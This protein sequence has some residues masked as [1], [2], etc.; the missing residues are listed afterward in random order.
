MR[1]A[2]TLSAVA[3]AQSVGAV[4]ASDIAF[5]LARIVY[6]NHILSHGVLASDGSLF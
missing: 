4:R 5:V 1:A 2:I 6:R 3:S